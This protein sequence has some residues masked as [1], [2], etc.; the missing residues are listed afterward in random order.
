MLSIT[1]LCDY[2]NVSEEEIYMMLADNDDAVTTFPA[3]KSLGSAELPK[4]LTQ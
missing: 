1:D 4:N 2:Y 3:N